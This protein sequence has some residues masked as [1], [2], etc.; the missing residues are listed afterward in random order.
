MR[1][2]RPVLDLPK[3]ETERILDG[4]VVAGVAIGLFVLLFSYGG[5]PT[6]IPTHFDGSGQPDDYSNK[7]MLLVIMG[8]TLAMAY[9]MWYLTKIPHKFNYMHRVTAENAEATYY[10]GRLLIRALNAGIVWVFVYIIWRTIEIVKG[11]AEGLG[12]WFLPAV[13]IVTIA[14]PI[15]MTFR[16]GK[17]D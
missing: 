5:L 8:I 11:N 7:A 4:L 15:Y 6:R 1:E 9:G 3:T 10:N 12:Q 14:I 16:M 2:E 17:K 13:L